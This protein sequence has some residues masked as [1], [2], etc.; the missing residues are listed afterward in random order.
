MRK[1]IVLMFLFMLTVNSVALAQSVEVVG[2][3][4]DKEAA[5]K[6]AMRAAVEQVVGTFLD[7][8]TLVSQSVVVQ[9]E[10]YSKAQ[11]FVTN[12]N[13]LEEGKSGD[14]YFIRARVDVNT[15]P[16]SQLQDRLQMIM[17]LGDPRIGVV[18]FKNSTNAYEYGNNNP[19]DD[20]TEQAV[21]AKLLSLGFTHV[22]DVSL[23]SKLRNSALL[24]SVYNGDSNLPD[25]NSSYGIDILV[26]VKSSVDATKI[27][28]MKQAGTNVETQLVRGTAN[29]TGKVIEFVTGTIRGTFEAKGQAV[30]ISDVTAQNKALQDVS[31]NIAQEV[32]RILRGEASRVFNGVQIIISTDDY[33][34]VEQLTKDLKGIYG[35]QNVYVREYQDGK[36]IMEVETTLKPHIILKRLREKSR[37]G[38]FNEGI[39]DR[40]MRLIVK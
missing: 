2:Y 37:L 40:S 12:I 16:D 15:N 38:L 31:G 13:V 17:L 21:N 10:I 14:N 3:G 32:E 36:G 9:D 18:A 26:L 27:T 20:I 4:D 33:S 8:K 23:T 5:T 30:D 34:K 24:N 1:L 35:V 6:D 7:S 29:V 28:L 11:G 22:A 39:S 19:Y 25:G